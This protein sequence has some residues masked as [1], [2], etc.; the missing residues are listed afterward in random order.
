MLDFMARRL[1]TGV[2]CMLVA[3]ATLVAATDVRAENRTAVSGDWEI[4]WNDTGA[5]VRH[6]PTGHSM[7]LFEDVK[8]TVPEGEEG[9]SWENYEMLSVTGPIVA[10][11]ATWYAEGGAHPSYGQSVRTIDLSR[12][13]AAQFGGKSFK[14]P[15]ANLASLF[16]EDAVFAQLSAEPAVRQA[17]AESAAQRGEAPPRPASLAALI[18]VADGG[19]LMWMHDR[20]LS[21]FHIAWRLG[22]KYAAV[23]IGLTHGC[24]AARGT[25]TELAP[26]FLPIPK[27]LSAAFAHAV[28]QGLLED[29]VFEKPGFNCAKASAPVEVLMCGN[30]ELAGLDRAVGDLFGSLRKSLPADRSKALR[31]EQ[32]K[33]LVARDAACAP[34]DAPCLIEQ[35]RGRLAALQAMRG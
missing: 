9:E 33:W 2:A 19:C 16:G 13:D 5:T 7:A 27:T 22:G 21:D 14:F 35:Y 32:R 31:D 20:L 17:I 8:S 6:R 11:G 12:V 18:E 30:A 28:E 4:L 1:T 25:F 15:E 10:Y 24:E 23:V 29:R 3:A 34:L 26:I